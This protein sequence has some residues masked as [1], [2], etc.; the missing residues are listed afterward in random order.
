M[1]KIVCCDNFFLEYAEDLRINILRE[2]Y[3]TQTTTQPHQTAKSHT[4]K[5]REKK[6]K[7]LAKVC[8][9]QTVSD[10]QTN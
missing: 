3:R 10:Q 6:I 4:Q 7:T 2:L 9:D 5:K 1:L 8:K